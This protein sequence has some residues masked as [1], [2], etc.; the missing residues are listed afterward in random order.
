M[1]VVFSDDYK[2]LD[3]FCPPRATEADLDDHLSWYHLGVELAV[4]RNIEDA[5]VACQRS[6]LLSPTQPETIRLLALLHTAA[7]AAASSTTTVVGGGDRRS[8]LDQAA[9]ALH[10]GL[11]E[12]PQD[13]ALLF[14]LAHVEAVRRGP[15]AGLGV[16]IALI[17]AW[18][19]CFPQFLSQRH[20]S[21][22]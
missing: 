6:L 7:A 11:A 2:S 17:D 9:R 15:A 20:E 8:H 13:F 22:G 5:L 14:T 4:K 3:C 21:G 16:Y 18:C 10:G 12:R 19:E 1:G